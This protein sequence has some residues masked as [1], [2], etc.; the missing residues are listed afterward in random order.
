MTTM[1]LFALVML[2]PVH[3]LSQPVITRHPTDITVVKNEPTTLECRVSGDPDPIVEWYKDGQLV[4]ID[5]EEPNPML[6]P[7]GSL[8]FLKAVHNKRQQD[9]GVYWCVASNSQGVARSANATLQIAFLNDEFR[10]VPTSTDVVKGEDVMLECSPP[11]GNPTPVVKW[12]K[13]GAYL[14]LTSAKRIKIDESGNL[15]IFKADLGDGGRY[16][17]SASNVAA[18][19]VSSPVRL[20]IIG[21]PSSSSYLRDN[22]ADHDDDGSIY[23]ITLESEE[24]PSFTHRPKSV[25]VMAGEDALLECQ[26]DG[27]PM[28]DITWSKTDGVIGTNKVKIIPR[29]GLKIKY[30]HPSDEGEYVCTAQNAGGRVTATAWL[31]VHAPPVITVPPE[32]HSQ[33]SV[34]AERV[35]LACLVIGTPA[36]LV[37]WV[38]EDGS[39]DEIYFSTNLNPA[40]GLYSNSGDIR[41]NGDGSLEIINPQVSHSGHYTCS[42]T[43]EVGSAIARA[44]LLVY[45]FDEPTS[46]HA[47]IEQENQLFNLVNEPNSDRKEARLR[48]NHAETTMIELRVLNPK[49]VRVNWKVSQE[50][51][52]IQGYRIWY[53]A[54]NQADSS[55]NFAQVPQSYSKTFEIQQ[56]EENTN[57][58]VFVQPF[59]KDVIGRPSQL[60]SVSTPMDLPSLAPAIKEARLL[61]ASSIFL[62]WDGIPV[63]HH[64]G[65][66]LGYEIIIS[67][68][69]T[70]VNNTVQPASIRQVTLFVQGMMA[71]KVYSI[72]I[73]AVNELGRGPL[74]NPLEIELDPLFLYGLSRSTVTPVYDQ[75]ANQM[76]LI[77][78]VIAICS[79]ILI[80]LSGILFY[81]RKMG[82]GGDNKHDGYLEAATTCATDEYY[83][84][85]IVRSSNHGGSKAD[86][87]W[88]DRKRCD[89]KDDQADK[90]SSASAYERKLL[91]QPNH[92]HTRM[93]SNSDTEYTYV[94]NNKHNASHF[95]TSSS[96]ASRHTAE[97]PE[98]YATTDIIKSSGYAMPMPMM[99]YSRTKPNQSQS[100]S[101]VTGEKSHLRCKRSAAQ[102]GNILDYIPPP[103]V[104]PPPS[105]R[106]NASQESVIS[107]KYL[108]S[109]PIY[110]STS[111]SFDQSSKAAGPKS[112][113]RIHPSKR[114][115]SEYQRENEVFSRLLPREVDSNPAESSSHDCTDPDL[116]SELQN[117]KN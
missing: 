115:G 44:N 42:S 32:S 92:Y 71:N 70:F 93:H 14:D 22:V 54:Q 106:Y 27:V 26:V 50:S 45:D 12:K 33:V 46:N 109:H 18:T 97:S 116:E 114:Y 95:A 79:F 11:R 17:C 35:V 47:I 94:E 88:I 68:N 6:L 85:Q 9:G 40:N 20:T 25:S 77:I 78:I 56:L 48:L 81:K 19:R 2:Q 53:K 10:I 102:A 110:Q 52:F 75:A 66:L 59:Y 86:G 16:E 84:H 51:A 64:N 31:R 39:A 65:P 5:P 107:P 24:P 58:H 13:D 49:T 21:V 82:K 1:I 117:F 38:K 74:S 67:G 60:M 101:N 113:H 99:N 62:S 4:H 104:H 108:F 57:Y 98:P 55:F 89:R 41:V 105:T 23:V 36:P 73:G 83:H 28:P 30:V 43:N 37:Y 72:Q 61:N 7:D 96:G 87:L 91:V 100:S 103:P 34:G 15:V 76:T 63:N 90:E 3:G 8:F 69:S 80:L 112:T 111:I 29:R